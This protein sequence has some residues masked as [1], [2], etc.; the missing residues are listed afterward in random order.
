MEAAET[1]SSACLLDGQDES[2]F[3]VEGTELFI[4]IDV[5]FLGGCNVWIQDQVGASSPGGTEICCNSCS[6]CPD[7]SGNGLSIDC[8]NVVDGFAIACD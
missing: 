8:N 6:T 4:C 7:G 5:S 2:C 1:S 3:P